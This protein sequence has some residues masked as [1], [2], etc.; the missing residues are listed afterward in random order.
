MVRYFN[1]LFFLIF[2]LPAFGAT[3]P[4]TVGGST[5]T[6]SFLV[7]SSAYSPCL[8]RVSK[9]PSLSPLIPDVDGSLFTGANSDAGNAAVARYGNQRQWQVG[10]PTVETALNGLNVSRATQADTTLYYGLDCGSGADTATGT[11]TTANIPM[12]STH[13]EGLQA[14]G[15]TGFWKQIRPMFIG[16][17]YVT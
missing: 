17:F 15:S 4:V 16:R 5:N 2:S 14:D 9:D 8:L 3:I 10:H 1:I 11:F 7:F 12:G 13:V 6:A